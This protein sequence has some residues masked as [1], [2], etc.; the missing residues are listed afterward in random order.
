[1]KLNYNLNPEDPNLSARVFNF[2]RPKSEDLEKALSRI[3]ASISKEV[4]KKLFKLNKKKNK[5]NSD[6][7]EDNS[8]VD[9][10]NKNG[11]VCVED[12]NVLKI[13]L[14]NI[15]NELVDSKLTNK[16]A[17]VQGSYLN[18]GNFQFKV[19]LNPPAVTELSLPVVLMSGYPIYANLSVEFTDT[20]D[21]D[22]KWYVE[23]KDSNSLNESTHA[24][25]KKI[26][27]RSPENW[28]LVSTNPTFLPSDVQVGLHIKITCQP[29]NGERL[30]EE[31]EVISKHPIIE[32]PINCPFEKRHQHTKS[33]T[34]EDR[35]RVISYNILADLYADSDFSRSFLFPYCPPQFLDINYRKQLLIKEIIGYNA[36]LICLQEVDKKIF[37]LELQPIL[38]KLDMEGLMKMKLGEVAE[39]CATFFRR[40]K[41]KYIES[42]D[43]GLAE[44]LAGNDS[45]K[46]IVDKI[47]KN[48]KFF[49]K[50][51]SRNSVLQTTLFQSHSDPTNFL[52]VATVHLYFHPRASN[53]RLL[54]S[55]LCI[56][57]LQ[58]L[59]ERIKNISPSLIYCG[60]LN[61]SSSSGVHEYLL[62]KEVSPT[63]ADWFSGGEEYVPDLHLKHELD[64]INATGFSRYTNYVGGFNGCLDYIYA[65]GLNALKV[66]PLPSHEE[67]TAH[68]ALPNQYF[69][70]DHLAVGCEF[71]WRSDS[72]MNVDE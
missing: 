48:A 69:P 29:K 10:V 39:G 1:M 45:N 24:K 26:P 5:K 40:S 22:I 67:V 59:I 52:I 56:S 18:L 17:W 30:G 33:L 64:L 16:E 68:T 38:E 9:S 37:D 47:S 60:D 21:S 46:D 49:E 4:N 50:F 20:K 35:F 58:T 27:K 23:V 7:Q 55:H 57:Y 2:S 28:S 71:A 34:S 62:G 13:E 72:K 42:Y 43:I 32:G 65:S 66:I 44:Y 70:S 36:D 6:I 19:D 15:D 25:P 3:T 63:H 53:I 8:D 14:Y 12:E 51:T 41:F 31:V 54:Q 61:A 11:R